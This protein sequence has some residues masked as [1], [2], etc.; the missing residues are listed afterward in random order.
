MAN[1]KKTEESK[2]EGLT[3]E[4]LEAA[5]D[6][7]M[8]GQR[9]ETEN[10]SQLFAVQAETMKRLA[11]AVVAPTVKAELDRLEKEY[12]SP[13]VEVPDKVAVLFLSTADLQ[14]IDGWPGYIDQPVPGAFT[15]QFLQKRARIRVEP[16]YNP[17]LNTNFAL[18]IMSTEEFAKIAP[19][20]GAISAATM[21]GAQQLRSGDGTV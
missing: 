5:I 17:G 11:E 6:K 2:V 1:E 18:Q 7:L 13:Y 10:V 21:I 9:I 15:K 19:R 20:G 16:V 3:K 4:Q 8:S 14:R 12:E